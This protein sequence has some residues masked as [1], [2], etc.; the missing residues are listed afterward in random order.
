MVL[1]H[2]R[3][4]NA[5]GIVHRIEGAARTIRKVAVVAEELHRSPDDVVAPLDEQRRGN[6]RVDTARHG[7]QHAFAHDQRACTRPRAFATSAG[8]TS[9]TR[10][11][12]ASVVNEPMLMRIAPPAMSGETPIACSTCD[13]E[14]LP[15]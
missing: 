9:M 4:T 7:D 8:N 10:S 12:L 11:T 1:T 15:L 2:E 3:L 14:M 13:G 5:P 6:G